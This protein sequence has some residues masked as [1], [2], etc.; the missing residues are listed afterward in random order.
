M[1]IDTSKFKNPI[2]TIPVNTGE[3]VVA[4]LKDDGV[5]L[6]HLVEGTVKN[7]VEKSFQEIIGTPQEVEEETM[8]RIFGNHAIHGELTK[9]NITESKKD[10]IQS[11]MVFN[12]YTDI[13]TSKMED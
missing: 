2:I 4:V 3:I 5:L 6:T 11:N 9:E 12:G 7:S 8:W 1:I 10:E 13:K